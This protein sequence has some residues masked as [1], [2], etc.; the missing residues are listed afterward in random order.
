MPRGRCWSCRRKLDNFFDD[1]AMKFIKCKDKDIPDEWDEWDVLNAPLCG[2]D[3]RSLDCL[4]GYRELVPK[5]V[6]ATSFWRARD[7]AR[8]REEIRAEMEITGEEW[9]ESRYLRTP[10][11]DDSD[12]FAVLA[13]H[14][15][16]L[17]A[18]RKAG[19]ENDYPEW[20]CYSDPEVDGL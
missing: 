5:F 17:Q 2:P 4:A 1:A 12:F 13:A 3:N 19:W 15:P 18:L 6:L 16:S 20:R 11:N 14:P 9:A 10:T 8:Q 7:A